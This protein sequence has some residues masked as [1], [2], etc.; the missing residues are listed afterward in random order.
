MK[1]FLTKVF[2]FFLLVTAVTACLNF[3]YIRL[4][5]SDPDNIKKFETIPSSIQVCNFGS[6]HGLCGFYY[7]D[8]EGSNC[9]NFAL[10]SQTLSY[11]KRLFDH[12][13][14]NMAEGAVVFIPVSYFSFF[15]NDERLNGGFAE[16]NKRYYRIL[17]SRLIKGY[18]VRTD[19]YVNIL[20]S[21]IAGD[22]F[23]KVMT[24]RSADTFDERWSK[25]AAADWV[26]DDAWAAYKRHIADR[27]DEKGNRLRNREEIDALKY[28]VKNCQKRGFTP[29]LVTVPLM[30]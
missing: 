29:V 23:I 15:G 9:F 11:D 21:L 27:L 19:I 12:Y 2:L 4:D 20:P 17:P 8:V 30:Q 13:E 24:G 28:M 10:S 3:A 25:P 16:K 18:D 5:K 1:K 6:S 26:K 22:K 7:E 14:K